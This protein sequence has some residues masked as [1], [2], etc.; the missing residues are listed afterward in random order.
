[1]ETKNK[2][3]ELWCAINSLLFLSALVLLILN[4]KG[5]V[6]MRHSQKIEEATTKSDTVTKYI[7]NDKWHT[8]YIKGKAIHDSIPYVVP[9]II[10]TASILKLFYTQYHY[11]DSICDTN[12]IGINTFD[13]TENK[14]KAHSFT[15]KLLQPLK[16]TTITNYIEK[17]QKPVLLFGASANLQQKQIIGLSPECLYL[18]KKQMG[19]GLG[20]DV[21]NN[22]YSLKVLYPIGLK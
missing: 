15:Y 14:L 19:F 13:I 2:L 18:S 21:L 22:S 10:D 6:G 9:T 7:Y 1:M 17:K 5:C 12:L 3:Q 8:I 11:R 4:Q 16:Q 20:Y